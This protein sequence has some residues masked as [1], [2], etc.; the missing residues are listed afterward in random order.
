[1]LG[2]VV[3]CR[4]RFLEVAGRRAAR[5]SERSKEKEH[6][7]QIINKTENSHSDNKKTENDLKKEIIYRYLC[8]PVPIDPWPG[9][10]PRP[11][12]WGPL[13]YAIHRT[14]DKI[15]VKAK[16]LKEA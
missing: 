7:I 10:G 15:T 1:M 6:Q 11:G 14:L 2:R 12:A 3:F 8:G 5:R 13:F 16:F 9:T 4:I